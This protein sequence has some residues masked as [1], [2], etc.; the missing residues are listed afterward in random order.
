MKCRPLVFTAILGIVAIMLANWG[1]ATVTLAP[2]TTQPKDSGL[3]A[4]GAKALLKM[5]TGE[6][7]E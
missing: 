4:V 6:H 5:V 3:V 7:D 2:T 1:G